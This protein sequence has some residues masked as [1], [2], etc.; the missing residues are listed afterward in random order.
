MPL[1]H[2][3]SWLLHFVPNNE[4]FQVQFDFL[5]RA[6]CTKN[7][8]KSCVSA[9]KEITKCDFLCPTKNRKRLFVSKAK[10]WNHSWRPSAFTPLYST[11]FMEGEVKC[12]LWKKLLAVLLWIFPTSLFPKFT[13]RIANAMSITILKN[14][15]PTR[16]DVLFARLVLSLL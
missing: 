11:P 12:S 8:W 6:A 5:S 2:Y 13:C 10:N 15:K 9:I 16:P 4:F 1:L 14:C 7:I 3:I